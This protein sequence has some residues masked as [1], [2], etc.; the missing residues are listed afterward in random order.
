M[1][2]LDEEGDVALVKMSSRRGDV[3]EAS[4]MVTAS[5]WCGEVERHGEV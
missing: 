3:L 4:E 1:R 5:S 2:H